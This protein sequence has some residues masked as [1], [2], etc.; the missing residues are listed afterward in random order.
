MCWAFD[1]MF[2]EKFIVAVA[3]CCCSK[4]TALR[5]IPD[6]QAARLADWL[7]ELIGTFGVM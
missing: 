2:L 1:L 6:K 7:R 3:V 4:Y 5:H